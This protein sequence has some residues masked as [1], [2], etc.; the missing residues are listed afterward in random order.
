MDHAKYKADFLSQMHGQSQLQILFDHLPDVYFFAKNRAGKFVMANQQFV[1]QCGVASESEILGKDDF[2]FFPASR[3][4]NYVRDD[5]S[6]METGRSIIDRVELAPDPHHS[7]NWFV[8][9]KIPLY[10]TAGEIIGVA[11]T[12]RDISRARNTLQPYTEM[13]IVLEYI[14]DHYAHPIEVKT[15]AALIH[16]SVSQFER[17]FWSTFQ[18]SPIK[19]I[20]DVRIRAACLQLTSGHDTISTIAQNC[21]FYDH[22]HLTRN[23]KK[24]MHI[25]P[26]DYR[27]RNTI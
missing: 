14:R 11:G 25:S 5:R 7:I 23:F 9:T 2:D 16:V 15:L 12:A 3:A 19:H 1:H 22:A 4:E 24:R 27:N 10:S 20:M 21:G 8:T 26:K 18:I 17:R 13:S 6:V